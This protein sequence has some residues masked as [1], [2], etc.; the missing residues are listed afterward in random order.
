MSVLKKLRTALKLNLMFNM[1]NSNPRTAVAQPPS[2]GAMVRVSASL[3]LQP[4]LITLRPS[5]DKCLDELARVICAED[6]EHI[7][8][9]ENDAESLASEE[10]CKCDEGEKFITDNV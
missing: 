8:S 3:S 1:V 2:V 10:T 6:N 9:K 5:L 4:L 7:H